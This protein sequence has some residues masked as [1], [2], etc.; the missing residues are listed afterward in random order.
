MN[1]TVECSYDHPATEAEWNAFY[2][3]EKLPAVVS[4][5]GFHTSQRF[6]ALSGGCLAYLA[7]HSID[8]PMSSS[9]ASIARRV[10][11]T[12]RDGRLMS[13]TGTETSM[14]ASTVC[15]L[16]QRTI[17]SSSALATPGFRWGSALLRSR[18]AA[19]LRT[20]LPNNA[21][22]REARARFRISSSW[23]GSR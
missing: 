2:S 16:S 7:V 1:Y 18:S 9:A 4:V 14:M 3:D 19:S 23:T 8:G 15:L 22:W 17:C 20:G 11:A 21:G 10:A 13:R 5:P 6:R 12:S